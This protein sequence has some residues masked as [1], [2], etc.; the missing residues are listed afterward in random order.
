MSI[1]YDEM[2]SEQVFSL[3]EIMRD[4]VCPVQNPKANM[5]NPHS[6]ILWYVE[7]VSKS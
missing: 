3:S 6:R 7:N 5:Q 1:E 4:V 2:K